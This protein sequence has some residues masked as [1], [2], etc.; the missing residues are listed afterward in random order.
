MQNKYKRPPDLQP[1]DQFR[2]GVY[3]KS[4]RWSIVGHPCHPRRLIVR[5]VT[6]PFKSFSIDLTHTMLANRLL[7]SR[8][9]A[10]AIQ[11]VGTPITLTYLAS[12]YRQPRGHFFRSKSGPWAFKPAFS[13]RGAADLVI[14]VSPPR[15]P[16]TTARML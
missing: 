4:C 5:Y 16:I 3:R 15:V 2:A 9:V 6:L 1:W 12:F 11:G 10:I 14:E 7:E 8:L 13:V